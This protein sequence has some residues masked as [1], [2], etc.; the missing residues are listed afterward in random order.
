MSLKY[1]HAKLKD[2][3]GSTAAAGQTIMTPS[4]GKAELIARYKVWEEK[5]LVYDSKSFSE[6]VVVMRDPDD[7]Y[8][9]QFLIP[10]HLMK[11]FFV[12]KSKLVFD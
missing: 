9:L 1:A 6:N 4:L 7:D 11:Q 5:G 12:G 2:D 8:A 3:D 10:A